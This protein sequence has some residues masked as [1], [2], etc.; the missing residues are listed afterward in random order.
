[1]SEM[2]IEEQ[3]ALNVIKWFKQEPIQPL[4]VEIVPTQKCNLNCMACEARG[5]VPYSPEKELTDDELSGAVD[6]VIRLQVTNIHFSG[7]G[8][9]LCRK[10]TVDLMKRIKEAGIACSIV[11]NGT[12]FSEEDVESLTRLGLDQVV[13][14]IDGPDPGTNDLL[15]RKEGAFASAVRSV[16]LFHAWKEKLGSEA[17]EIVIAPVISR[18]NYDKIRQFIDMVDALHA[19]AL[20]IQPMQVKETEVGKSLLLA[21]EH[22]KAF[23]DE[24]KRSL[25]KADELDVCN[26]ILDI[27]PELVERSNDL[28]ELIQYDSE[29]H[30]ESRILSIPCYTPWFFINIGADGEVKTCGADADTGQNIREDSLKNIWNGQ[31]FEKMRKGLASKRV[32]AR[33]MDCCAMS[34]ISFGRKLRETIVH[35]EKQVNLGIS[36]D[37]TGQETRNV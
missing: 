2:N 8:E 27:E 23:I 33:C 5:K 25:K 20:M 10:I 35:L 32:P 12:L 37:E 24:L 21:D 34:V 6:Q 18:H 9:P 22:K 15:R 4:S 1:M 29:Q 3:R 11:T 13:F 19:D 16:E 14:S 30:E 31:Y 7:G 36:E 17:P 26:N 28:K